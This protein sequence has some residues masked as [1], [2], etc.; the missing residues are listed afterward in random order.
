MIIGGIFSFSALALGSAQFYRV[1][2]RDARPRR[3]HAIDTQDPWSIVGAVLCRMRVSGSC[4]RSVGILASPRQGRTRSMAG[5]A[6][7][8]RG[9]D[10]QRCPRATDSGVERQLRRG[11]R[12]RLAGANSVP[13][14]GR[15]ARPALDVETLAR[16]WSATS[17]GT[18]PSLP[19]REPIGNC[20]PTCG[21]RPTASLPRGWASSIC[22]AA[23]TRPSTKEGQRSCG[24]GI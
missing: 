14:E 10:H 3:V 7:R 17:S 20:W 8:S 2:G 24:S 18:S 16:P 21:P 19:Y 6:G 4:L 15:D 22:T 13:T 5:C 12:Q 23:A 1:S 11:V 9:C